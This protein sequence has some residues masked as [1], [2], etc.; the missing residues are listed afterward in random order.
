MNI[1]GIDL[2]LLRIFDAMMQERSATRVAERV[3]LSQPAVSAALARLRHVT[4]DELFL[5][6][7]GKMV[8]TSR[9]EAMHD[10]VRAAMSAIEGAFDAAIPFDP[11]TAERRYRLLGSDYFSTLLMPPLSEAVSAVAP[12]ILLQMLDMPSSE[13][14]A[15]LAD[16]KVD[17]AVSPAT[18]RLPDYICAQTLFRSYLVTVNARR[19]S[20][21]RDAGVGIGERIPPELFCSIPHVMMSMDGSTRGTIDKPLEERGLFRNV[22][23]TLP[24]FHAVALA[25]ASGNFLANLPVHYAHHVAAQFDLEIYLPPYD[26]PI[27]DA[28]L[29]WHRR[30]EF[31]TANLWLRR[32][33]ESVFSL[34]DSHLP[35]D[36]IL[37]E[38]LL[39]KSAAT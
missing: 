16:G 10:P 35:E 21:L 9:A 33:I 5:R 38:M 39:A 25:V 26:A 34:R 3:G 36:K 23:L 24:H 15:T 18:I 32:Q 31:D 13:V 22:R 20:R 14:V 17:V 7:G 12:N 1:S 28:N 37:R 2:N 8:P 19:N 27:L 30:H 6:E 4:R 29:Y 11:V